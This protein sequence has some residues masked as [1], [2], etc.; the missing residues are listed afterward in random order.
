MLL[1]VM[2]ATQHPQTGVAVSYLA[3]YLLEILL[4]FMTLVAL[5]PLVSRVSNPAARGVESSRRRRRFLW[6]SASLS[7]AVDEQHRSIAR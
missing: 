5:G 3:V 7:T 2:D 6:P 1:L 4:L